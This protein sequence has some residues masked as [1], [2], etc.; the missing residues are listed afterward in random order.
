MRPL[1]IGAGIGG[2]CAASLLS[3]SGEKPLVL[4]K[5]PYVGGR[6]TSYAYA[7]CL[8]DNG[9]H[10]SYY[11]GGYVGGHVGEIL[12]QLRQDVRLEKIEPPLSMY[13]EGTI[14]SVV[15]FAHVPAELRPFLLRCA[16]EIRRIPY[17]KTHEYDD[18]TVLEWA[19]QR[20]RHP[21]LLKHFNLSSYFAVTAKADRASVGEYFR[22]LQ[23]ATSICEGL[24]YPEEGGIKRIA[25]SLTAG[26]E[27]RGGEVLT[28]AEVVSME[29]DGGSVSTVTYEKGGDMHETH[30]QYV[31]FNPPVYSILDYVTCP[32][33][34]A[35]K[36]RTMKG[37]HTGPSTQ[38]YILLDTTLFKTKS[39]VLLPPEEVDMWQPGEHSAFFSP[40]NLSSR[41][42]PPGKQ[43]LLVAVPQTKKD[44]EE[45]ALELLEKV[46]PGLKNHVEWIY[47]FVTEIVDG[48]AKHVGFVGNHKIKVT[49]PLKNL[50][51]VGDTVE[52]TGPGMELP[53]DSA[54]RCWDVIQRGGRW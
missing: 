29:A 25:D 1:V 38:V 27:A 49:S 53:A 9:W 5:K 12:H 18:M 10:A 51:F 30:P 19:Q 2:L 45:E 39:L 33:E 34:F 40:S 6:A 35:E 44:I 23:I 28:E 4:E 16:A 41:V 50:F 20:T 47:S 48:L 22:V 17:E 52:G 11:K 46:F 43:L 7:G 14:Q 36:A 26:I 32:P 21:L 3:L 54:K 15:G 37:H 13:R 31:I 24:G 8:L 42:A